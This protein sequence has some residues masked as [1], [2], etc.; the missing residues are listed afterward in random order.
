MGIF[1]KDNGKTENQTDKEVM[2]IKVE[3]LFIKEIGKMEK[4]KVLDN[5]QLKK[6]MDIL[7]NGRITKNK[8]KDAIFTQINNNMMVNGLVIKNL[9][10]AHI[11]IKMEIYILEDGRMIEDQEK[12]K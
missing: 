1:I 10:M 6:V 12:E 7:V 11:N 4:N 9:V 2:F 3:K 8:E 5:F